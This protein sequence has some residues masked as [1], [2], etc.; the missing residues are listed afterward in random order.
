MAI[1]H[2]SSQVFTR[3]KGHS[4][5]SKAAY[6]SAEKLYDERLE[7]IF[8]YSKKSDLLHKE[9][10]L[11]SS[12]SAKYLDRQTLW[13]AAE[14][15]EKRKDS[16]VAREISFSLPREL[17]EEQNIKLAQEFVRDKFVHLGMIADMCIHKGHGND[18][19]HV[20]VMLT[21]RE[22]KGEEFGQ[23]V[24]EWN[25]KPLYL[26]WR[27]EWANYA[28]KH[29]AKAGLD[30][31]IDHRSNKERGIDLEPQN[32]I[33]SE[34][35]RQRFADKVQEH[36]GIAQRNGEKIFSDP[37][38][39]LTTL[40]MQQ[41]TFR[42]ED[43][44]KLVNRHTID[45]E[46]FTKVFE[47]VMASK[48]LIKL[49]A[50]EKGIVRYT[51][52]EM[53][54]IEYRM[55]K[56][57]INKSKASEHEVDL[58]YRDSLIKQYGLSKEQAE[59]FKHISGD[60]DLAC[61][62]GFAG[63]GKSYMLK[64]AKDSWE[65]DGYR[66]VGMTLSGIAAQQ[67]EAGSG[68]KSY[69]VANRIINWDNDRERLNAK[70][71]IVVDEAGMLGSRSIARIIDEATRSG[72][73]VILVGDPEQ[74]K[75][76]DA[77][78]AFRALLE[79]I[80]YIELSDIRRQ[81]V[82]WQQ[83][84]TKSF[85]T[86]NTRHALYMYQKHDYV[87]QF[88]KQSDAMK[89]MVE[90]WN[91]NRRVEPDKT[92][93]MLAYRKT[94]VAELNAMAREWRKSYG[95]LGEA[96]V[97]KVSQGTREFAVNDIVYF[98]KNDKE[99]GVKN[100]TI[101]QV[102]KI[103]DNKLEISVGQEKK[104][105]DIRDYDNIDHGYAATVYKVQG[106]TV[107][108]AYVLASELFNRH[109][110]YVAGSRHTESLELFWSE[111]R[112]KSFKNLV[113]IFSRE[114][115][116]DVS[117]DYLKV[118]TGSRNIKLDKELKE[119]KLGDNNLYPSLPSRLASGLKEM[120]IELGCKI[121]L[122]AENGEIGKYLG[123]IVIDNKKFGI[124]EKMAGIT[125]NM[126]CLLGIK[127]KS[128]FVKEDGE[129]R[130]TRCVNEIGQKEYK[131]S[132][133]REFTLEKIRSQRIENET[134]EAKLMI[135]KFSR[136]FS[137][138]EAVSLNNK[139][140][141][142]QIYEAL[143]SKLPGILPEFGLMQRGQCY[144]STTGQKIDGSIGKKSKIYIYANNPG[145][146]VDY[147]KG[148][149]SVWDYIKERHMPGASNGELFEYLASMAGLRSTFEEKFELLKTEIQPSKPEIV[150]AVQSVET[151]SWEKVYQ[152]SLN[153]IEAKNNQ[154]TKY[155]EERGYSKEIITKMGIGYIPAK[156]DLSIWLKAN[157]ISDE[158]IKEVSIAL[159][160]IGGSHKLVVPYYDQMGKII[161]LSARNIKHD[162]D[163]GL[164]KYMYTKGLAKNSTLLNIHEVNPTKEL[165]IV[166]GML[167]C[168]HA[169]AQGIT[170]VVALG[171]TGFNY[172]Q[173]ELIKATGINKI[174]LCLDSDKAGV[175]ATD[176]IAS[177]IC[178]KLPQAHVK[179]AKLP[180]G[181]KDFDELIKIKGA[182]ISTEVLASAKLIDKEALEY[183]RSQGIE[184]VLE[185]EQRLSI[186]L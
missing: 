123:D 146:L 34:D 112:L 80:G 58:G 184:K 71:I 13:N 145:M 24:V 117:L 122:T 27:E 72:A 96:R 109:V 127:E 44:A 115:V 168:L 121:Q 136:S 144:V 90:A 49:G 78:A 8:D 81:R 143:Y 73:K 150:Q 5:V 2:F 176:R 134:N 181:I 158:Q 77:G 139:I 22:I 185:P 98:L 164:G 53:L 162:P 35:G 110:S 12:V 47:K 155:L 93:I 89:S 36:I 52:K 182:Q 170:N 10:M 67:L 88:V 29:L 126:L 66:V 74:L 129:V 38:I 84:A 166:E 57:G 19:P 40:T 4:A 186:K 54:D 135:K 39:L 125:T 106:I 1:Y 41:S 161:G 59:A 128:S 87:H 160:Y 104:K 65:K 9:I 108:R 165:T 68:I 138:G 43:I 61:V 180:D 17:S 137:S 86:G 119:S 18:Q 94:E 101:G 95:E 46:Q 149:K 92:R 153:K 7:Q 113:R 79:R 23:K 3:S 21:M 70:D 177:L 31:K 114:Q 116:K 105:I 179:V 16:Q 62:I 157:G 107:N 148:N 169:K 85:A 156:K 131:L 91:E 151:S 133:D 178:D 45:A 56:Q 163:S 15:A 63:T 130:I 25:K 51:S 172:S 175:E 14:A 42:V 30:L 132:V 102:T 6:R 83:D 183:T 124:V 99:L 174:T 64:A 76:I 55:V 33:G 50:D 159:G 154:V 60:R 37:S 173:V 97:F 82:K 120:V 147:T 75:A 11:P 118:A 28:N 111:E 140:N 152:Y 141:T 32:K 100:G 167:D 103:S 171:G 142:S 48:E 69:T 20:H 26:H